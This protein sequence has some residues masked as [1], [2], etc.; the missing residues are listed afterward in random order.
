MFIPFSVLKGFYAYNALKHMNKCHFIAD[1][2][3]AISFAS[4]YVNIPQVNNVLTIVC[5]LC[6]FL[7]A[8]RKMHL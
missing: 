2:N 8:I 6:F 7:I 4:F 1:A 3:I 5:L